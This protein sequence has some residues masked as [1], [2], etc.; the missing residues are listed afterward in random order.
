MSYANKLPDYQDLLEFQE[1]W[2]RAIARAWRDE[3]FKR[4]LEDDACLALQQAFGYKMPWNINLSVA[5]PS[6]EY[7]WRKAE[8]RWHLPQNRMTFGIPDRPALEEEAIALA[9]YNDAGPCYL[10]TCC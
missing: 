5:S 6:A 7:G 8:Q 4:Q 9:S 3:S 1:V 2:L 10:F